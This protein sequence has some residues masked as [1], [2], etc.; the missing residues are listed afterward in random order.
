VTGFEAS[1][2]RACGRQDYWWLSGNLQPIFEVMPP[3]EPPT[4]SRAAYARVRGQRSG[5]GRYGHAG[6]WRYELVVT[7]VLD[8]SADT[9]GRC[10]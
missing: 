4:Y 5:P 10:G 2:F 8:A 9:L 7:E 6:G 3:A 1:S